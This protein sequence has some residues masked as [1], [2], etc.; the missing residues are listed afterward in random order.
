MMTKVPVTDPNDTD[1]VMES[2]SSSSS[3]DE[4]EK[5][6]NHQKTKQSKS[7]NQRKLKNNKNRKNNSKNKRNNRQKQERIVGVG[8]IVED[9]SDSEYEKL[10]DEYNSPWRNRRPSSRKWIEPVENY[11]AVA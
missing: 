8:F 3:S 10:N 7:V 5:M 9:A 4:D 11:H 1:A 2:N 6:M